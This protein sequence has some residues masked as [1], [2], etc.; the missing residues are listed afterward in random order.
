VVQAALAV[1]GLV[2]THKAQVALARL[3]QAVVVAVD[4]LLLPIKL[5]VLAV[6][7]S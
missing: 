7:A 1:E 6:Q 3:I 5:V 4:M 2:Q